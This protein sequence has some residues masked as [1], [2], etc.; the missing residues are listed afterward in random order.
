MYEDEMYI[1][2]YILER[3]EKKK[4]Q[5]EGKN[6]YISHIKWNILPNLPIKT[7]KLGHV[8]SNYQN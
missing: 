3:K 8:K 7:H 5:K 6:S 1:I 2:L 4:T